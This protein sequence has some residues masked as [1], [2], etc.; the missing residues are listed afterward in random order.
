MTRI[1]AGAGAALALT[2]CAAVAS[3]EIAVSDT[4]LDYMEALYKHFHLNPELSLYE[5]ETAARMA[6][7]FEAAGY[8]VTREVGGTGVVGVLQNGQGPTVML[9]GDMDALPLVELTGVDYASQVTTIDEQGRTVGVMHACG[10]D[11]HITNLIG[12]ARKLSNMRDAWRGTLV[13]V[14]QPAEERGLG[15]RAMIEDGL[16]ERFPRPDYNLGLHVTSNLPA[17]KAGYKPEFAMANV[18]SVDI[19]VHGTGGH[20]AAPHLTHDP[21]VLS[22][23]IVTALQT[24]VARNLNP[25]EEGVVTVGSIHGGTKHNII[26]DRV[27]LQLTVRSY[28]D[29]NRALLLEGIARIAK[30]Q[31]RALG[32]PEDRL[33]EVHVKNEYTPALYNDPGLSNRVA[34]ALRAELGEDNVELSKP[35]MGGE[36]FA[37]FGRTQPRIPSF[38][39]WLGGAEPAAFAAAKARGSSLPA[40][41]SP[42][43]LPAYELTLRTGVRAMT[44]A[45]LDLL[46]KP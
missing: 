42:Y 31:A 27:D 5:F 39:F 13:L 34:D 15:A 25:I 14:A 3:A 18:D 35:V 32:L 2:L 19:V 23:Y 12:V 46:A 1:S 7:E 21:V 17:G 16:F 37:R 36:D 30:A 29:D 6:E 33:P 43:F 38:Y 24:L 22:A 44:A 26:S 20:G 10:H 9:R 41:H 28:S 8:T 45:A 4:E 40:T 11:I